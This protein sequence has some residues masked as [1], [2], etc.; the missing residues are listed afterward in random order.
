MSFEQ[1]RNSTECER[2]GSDCCIRRYHVSKE[3]REAAAGE[4]LECMRELHSIQG[5][6]AVTV[7]KKKTGTIMGHLPRRLSGVCSF[8]LRRGSTMSFTVTGGE[9]ILRR[10]VYHVE[11][12]FVY[13]AQKRTCYFRTVNYCCFNYCRS[14]AC[15][16]I[17]TTKFSQITV[18]ILPSA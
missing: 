14:L 5:Q 4:V 3:M 15:E 12:T 8:F 10:S 18:L 16:N 13:S 2:S 7:K 9:K 1:L 17:L 11:L 6:Y